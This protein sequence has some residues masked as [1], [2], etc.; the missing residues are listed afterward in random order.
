MMR[1]EN[2]NPNAMDE[3]FENVAIERLVDGA[4]L[5]ATAARRLCP[6]GTVSRPIYKTGPYAGK[7]WTARDAGQL[8][9]SIR[10]VRQ[11]TKSGKAFSKKRNVRV[12]AGHFLAYYAK[13]VEFNGRAFMRPALTAS[14]AG[15]KEIIGA[16]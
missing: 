7:N 3:T 12:Y 11:K 16:K 10:V 1:V 14:L 8:K 13:I 5:V 4:E 9:R 2:W 15:L 6:V